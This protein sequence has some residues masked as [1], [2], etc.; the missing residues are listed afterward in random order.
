MEERFLSLYVA[1]LAKGKY[2]ASEAN[3]IERP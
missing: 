2:C 1:S 3:V